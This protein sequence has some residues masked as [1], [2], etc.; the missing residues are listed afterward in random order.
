MTKK[1]LIPII[2]LSLLLSGCNKNESNASISNKNVLITVNGEPIFE[3]ELE[4]IKLK[5][6]E[7]K[8]TD[9]EII[10]GMILELITL[11][12][13]DKFSISISQED[14]DSRY[15][16]LV[17]LEQSLFYEKAIEQYG[18]EENYKDSLYYKL[19]YDEVSTKIKKSFSD[20][21]SIENTLL[22]ERTQDYISQYTSMDFEENNVDKEIFS[23]EVTQAYKESFLFALEDLYFKVWQYKEA[24]ISKLSFE[25]YNRN[26]LFQV[27]EYDITA[28]TLQFKGKTYEMKEIAL[29][30]IQDRFGNYFYLSN[31]LKDSYSVISG[32][33]I[34]IPSKNVQGLYVTLGT[35]SPI[36]IKLIVSPVLSL[37]NDF[38]ENGII[39][40][41]EDGLNKIEYIQS[42][43]GIYYSISANME[44]MEL[45]NLLNSCIPYIQTHKSLNSNNTSNIITTTN[46]FT[47]KIKL[48]NGT[49]FFN[50]YIPTTNDI[51]YFNPDTAH[52]EK[53]NLE[54]VTEYLG[55]SFY[56]SYIPKTLKL[57]ENFY[58]GTFISE[59]MDKSIYWTV[60]FENDKDSPIYDNFGLFYSNSFNN[61]YN[62]LRK[63][64]YIEVSKNK[65]PE[66]DT[67]YSYKTTKKSKIG[68]I[69]LTIGFYNAPYYKSSKE[70]VGYSK[71]FVAEF[72][73]DNV[74]YRI[75][76]E[77]LS[78]E[79][80]IKILTSISIFQ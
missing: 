12:Q 20:I 31:S 60:A 72:I 32:K 29:E 78:Q 49:L 71:H 74:G 52:T 50:N 47:K 5:Y 6:E 23:E 59:S 53:W 33:A 16:E 57:C 77:N 63:N 56:P 66:S 79:D 35:D 34:H 73:A 3:E 2:V 28:D 10:E 48:A 19:V 18:S 54:Q 26:D 37:Y 58:S 45:K 4:K 68:N 1:F 70:C 51:A 21:F 27:Q 64:L 46:N 14:V 11:Q 7:K 62:P 76:S 38:K 61:E 17:N 8:L 69:E 44:Y 15:N 39:E 40:G 41:K 65:I 36:T 42:E 67:V 9:S 75:K 80:F 43:L 13:A 55:T 25:N 22:Q 30:E 24:K